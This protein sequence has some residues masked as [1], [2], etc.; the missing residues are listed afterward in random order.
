LIKVKRYAGRSREEGKEERRRVVFIEAPSSPS[1]GYFKNALFNV[2]GV[3]K[4]EWPSLKNW[5]IT[6]N[7]GV[8]M[9]HEL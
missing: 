3:S 5:V 2:A 6:R 7:M 1:I 9:M 8:M 4:R